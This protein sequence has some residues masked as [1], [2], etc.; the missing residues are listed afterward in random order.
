MTSSLTI[1]LF[2]WAT[3]IGFCLI[4]SEA[5]AKDC[6]IKNVDLTKSIKAMPD[7][8]AVQ[9]SRRRDPNSNEPVLRHTIDYINGATL[10]LEQQ[11]CLMYNLRLTLLS[12]EAIP[13]E[14]DLRRLGMVLGL[15]PVWSTY[16]KRYDPVAVAVDEPKSEKFRSMKTSA[17]QFSYS[18]ENRLDAHGESSEIIT[19]FMST[20]SQMVPYRSALSLYIGVGGQ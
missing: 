13:G 10:V 18:M 19:S 8:L 11:N 9:V 4:A 17:D 5:P 7:T 3:V 2:K 6:T 16:F 15:T 12:P 1:S 14:T 20:D